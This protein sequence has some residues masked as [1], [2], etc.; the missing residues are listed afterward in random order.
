MD[1]SLK[2]NYYYQG[3]KAEQ[4]SFYRIPKQLIKD[5]RFRELSSDAKCLYGLLLDRMSLS[6]KNGWIDKENRLYIHY[7]LAEMMQDF[8]CSKGTCTK[9]MRELDTITGVGLIERKRQ[10]LGRPDIIYVKNLDTMEPT[11]KTESKEK[12]PE[13][14]V[15]SPKVQTLSFKKHNDKNVRD[16]NFETE[17]SKNLFEN[18]QKHKQAT[19]R[20]PKSEPQEDKKVIPDKTDININ[21][22]N[23]K[24]NKNNINNNILYSNPIYP[25]K[26]SK[27]YASKAN[28][29]TKDEMDKMSA[30]IAMIKQ[31]VEYDR[32]V[33]CDEWQDKELY[34]ELYQTICDVVCMQRESIKVAGAVCPHELVK[35]RF[36]KLK[37]E[38]LQYVVDCLK[39]VTNS[40]RNIKAYM[41]T[42]LYNAP[43]T[44]DH[45]YTNMVQYNSCRA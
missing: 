30:Y 32:L 37:S 44:I 15:V 6:E 36:L 3:V 35:S 40:I 7:A 28:E 1:N 16:S 42:S 27:K 43:T 14:T 38:H 18:S 29:V 8:N 39:K 45:Y 13:N 4:F 11:Q 17:V 26:L 21:N 25:S 31:N 9:I 2:F 33:G 5:I 19:F 23:N 22:K 41:I 12:M 10:G 34:T 24:N 20:S